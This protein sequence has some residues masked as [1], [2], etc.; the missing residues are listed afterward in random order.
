MSQFIQYMYV[1]VI[2]IIL[3]ITCKMNK[4]LTI[5]QKYYIYCNIMNITI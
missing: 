4:I 3:N 1:Q 5:L 2:S